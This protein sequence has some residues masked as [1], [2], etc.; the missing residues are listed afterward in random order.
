[1][2]D[3]VGAIRDVFIALLISHFLLSRLYRGGW[4]CLMGQADKVFEMIISFLKGGVFREP[5]NGPG[6]CWAR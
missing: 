1:M 5:L 3:V 2:K 4:R 6:A